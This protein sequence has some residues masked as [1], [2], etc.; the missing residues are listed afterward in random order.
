MRDYSAKS[1][2][3]SREIRIDAKANREALIKAARQLFVRRGGDIP[4]AEIAQAAGVSRPTFYRNF[5]DRESLILAV[6]HSNID[7]LERYARRY[8]GKPEAFEK[9]IELIVHQHVKYQPL[10]PMVTTQDQHLLDRVTALFSKPVKLAKEAG[11][12]R[13]EFDPVH[14]VYLM[15]MMLG[16]ALHHPT[17]NR[18]D[19][20][21][22]AMKWVFEGILR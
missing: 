13:P 22:R 21:R 5:P 4:L 6:F 11:R 17:T 10:V 9:L 2:G 16:G 7:F 1:K 12:L 8:E 14:D 20:A 19:Q 3:S 15:I 18:K